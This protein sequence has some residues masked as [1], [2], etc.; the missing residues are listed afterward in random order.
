[1][2]DQNRREL[3]SGQ[4]CRQWIADNS[5]LIPAGSIF[6]TKTDAL[7]ALVDGIET[8]AGGLASAVGE[9]LSATDVK[10]SERQDLLDAMEPVRDAARAAEYD[11]PGTRD[12][13]RYNVAMSHHDL[14]AAGRSF[15]AGGVD[16]QTLLENWGA[17]LKW[18]LRVTNACDAF[19]AAFGLKDSAVASRI[20]ANV[21]ITADLHEMTL[22]KGSLR[23]LVKNYTTTNPGARAAWTA[24]A[25]VERAPKKKDPPTPLDEY[26]NTYPHNHADACRWDFWTGSS[27]YAGKGAKP[28]RI[29]CGEI[30]RS[31]RAPVHR[32]RSGQRYKSSGLSDNRPRLESERLR[33]SL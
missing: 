8:S 28:T 32:Y 17:P 16:D 13:Y 29:S 2:N 18:P 23:H 15:A 7:T 33:R 11:V 27:A 6:A 19:E 24:A 5:A 22:L 20:A 12:R 10:G 3:E 21:D 26:E 9:G 25:H 1:M 14:L 31:T 4:R 30:G